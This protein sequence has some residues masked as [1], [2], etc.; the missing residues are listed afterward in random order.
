MA[1][2]RV[3][4]LEIQDNSKSLKSQY[5]EAVAE[6]QKV[7][8]QYGETSQ[9]AIK[10]AKA[11]AQLKDQIEFSKDLVKG[12]N[13]DAKFDSLSRSIGGVLNGFQAYEGAMGLVGVE[14]EKLQETMLKVQSA[15]ALSQGI[16]GVFEAKDSF[17]Q[18]GTVIKDAAIKLGILTVVEAE[19]VAV[20][21]AQVVANEQAATS[22]KATGVAAKTSLN[23][24][25]GALA[26]TGI[27]LLVIALGTIV[28]YWDDIKAAVSGVSKEQAKLNEETH[29]NFETSKE[30]LAT[31]DAQDNILK[32]QGKS[33]RE[34]LNLKIAKVNT[35]IELGKVEL[36]NV[37][38]TSKA[39]EEAAIKNYNLTKQI[40]D[41][42]L[43]T[44]LFLPKL[45]LMPIDM[46]I[47]GANKVSEALGFGKV[48]A[49]D[50]GKTM[51]NMQDK[52]SGFI[53]GSIFN[54]PEVQAE[55]EKTRKELE[56]Q[57]KD[58]ENQKAGFQLQVQAIDKANAQKSIDAQ[59]DEQDAKLEAEKEYN[60][61]LR[62]YYDAIEQE[63]QGQ[64]TD[65]KE[66]ELQALDNKF[67][68]LYKAADDAN[69]SDKELLLKHQQEI[70]DINLKYDELAKEEAKKT[71]DELAK[72][73]KEK[74]DEIDRVNKEAAEKEVARKKRNKDF[75][76]EM[77][78]SGFNT[79]ASLTELFG[80]KSEKAAR[81]AFRINKGAQIASAT[82]ST[83][84]SAQQAYASQF[85]PFPDPSSPIRGAV[86]AGAAV[87]AGLANIAKIASQKFEG[88]GSSGG[89]GGV[90]AASAAA[91][92]GAMGQS[93]APNFS[94]IGSSGINQLAQLQQTPTQ[95]YVVSGEVTTAQ[96]LDRNRLQNAT[97]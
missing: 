16:Q 77:A 62:A 48:I 36:K 43:D 15:M 50:M 38:L 59:K 41:F 18:L 10:A 61:K 89:G 32:L 35:A 66:K 30:Q 91:L 68:A 71:A 78:I 94:I 53:T 23:G 75:A 6:L 69:Q 11:A 92:S 13:P 9:Q 72:I 25:K 57:L 73:E 40:V 7:S 55:G 37:I 3:I 8:A 86:A 19:N 54:V 14:S 85:V 58:L 51:E 96:A 42:I 83:Y 33:E 20:T 63:R 1:E 90:G 24:I 88:G 52:F 17:L 22:F 80:K 29:K 47:A 39:E 65:A 34:I 74:L 5:K 21:E 93:S 64:I 60:E 84:Q 26:A 82:M 4:E 70:T 87:F 81:N 49:F 45:M 97:L 31:L 28:A 56:K 27:G 46:A 12:F 44:A 2:K 67:E 95:A 79:I 76:V